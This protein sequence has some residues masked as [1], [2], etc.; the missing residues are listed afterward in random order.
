MLNNFLPLSSDRVDYYVEFRATYD[1]SKKSQSIFNTPDVIVFGFSPYMHDA[2][3][4][5]KN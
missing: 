5:D 3:D 1:I 4:F 2:R